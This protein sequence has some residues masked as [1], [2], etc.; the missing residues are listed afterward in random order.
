MAT[1]TAAHLRPRTSRCP[2]AISTAA[3]GDDNRYIV[4]VGD[5]FADADELK[6]MV[7]CNIDGIGDVRLAD[8]AEVEMTDNADDAYAKVDKNR[9]V[10]LSLYKSSTASTSTVSNAGQ[11]RH[12]RR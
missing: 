7:L 9:A 11:R 8:V 10:L 6:D 2:P 12:G 4:K 5:A 3:H 1:L